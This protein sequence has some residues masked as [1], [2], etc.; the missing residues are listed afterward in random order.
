MQLFVYGSDI[1]TLLRF[2]DA[3]RRS[4]KA[5][6]P[7]RRS[8]TE[9]DSPD[10]SRDSVVLQDSAD[11]RRQDNS[12][13]RPHCLGLNRSWT[14]ACDSSDNCNQQ[15]GG[16]Q[17]RVNTY[18]PITSGLE[19]ASTSSTVSKKVE[20]WINSCASVSLFVGAPSPLELQ[21]YKLLSDLCD[22]IDDASN[23]L[24]LHGFITG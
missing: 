4:K 3:N 23:C 8:V 1:S 21:V 20:T 13:Q 6:P 14:F 5:S 16:R 9:G 12:L 17:A 2:V 18:C 22:L 19:D 7:L 10:G 15:P 24:V 11:I